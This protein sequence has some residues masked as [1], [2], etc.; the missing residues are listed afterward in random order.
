M[1]GELLQID[2]FPDTTEL[3]AWF[4]SRAFANNPIGVNF[5]PE[6]LLARWQNGDPEDELIRR[7]SA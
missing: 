5:D 7:G 4:A 6:K 2:N 3:A 1:Q